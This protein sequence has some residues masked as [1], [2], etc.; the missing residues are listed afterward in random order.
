MGAITMTGARHPPRPRRRVSRRRYMVR[1]LVALAVV[2]VVGGVALTGA[3]GAFQ[4][5][6]GATDSEAAGTGSGGGSGDG[7]APGGTGDPAATP[8]VDTSGAVPGSA[9]TASEPGGTAPTAGTTAVPAATAAPPTSAPAGPPTAAAP[10]TL[11]ILGDSD[12]GT[13]GPYLQRLLD[14]TGIVRTQLDYKV[15]S[16]LARPDFFDWPAHL[17]QVLPAADP[18]IVVVTFG[19]NDAQGLSV[20]D[21]SFIVQAPRGDGDA[22]WRAEYGAR[23]GAVMDRI[24]AD[25]RRLIWVGIPNDDNPEVTMR[26]QVQD[27]VAKA[28]AAERPDVVFVDTWAMFSGKEGGWAEYHVDPRDGQGK[29]VRAADGFHLNT[30]GAEILALAIADEVTRALRDL[31]AAL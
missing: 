13:F 30:V 17:E 28:A 31:G 2:A 18:D 29:K 5:V 27:E 15:S 14:E 26:L 4:A 6:F 22:E 16:G 3:V 20:G 9:D 25:G 24:L 7:V 19:G 10:A 11:L 21:G 12:A 23:V 8:S 1:R